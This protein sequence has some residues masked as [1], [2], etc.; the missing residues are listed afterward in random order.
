MWNWIDAKGGA[1]GYAAGVLQGEA[2]GGRIM[3]ASARF[4]VLP[5]VGDGPALFSFAANPSA[6]VQLTN[7]GE[8]LLGKANDLTIVVQP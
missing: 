5:G 7:G 4:R 6:H 3:V 8:N 2:V 1:I